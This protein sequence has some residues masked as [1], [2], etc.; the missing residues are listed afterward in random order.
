MNKI[1]TV[2]CFRMAM[3]GFTAVIVFISAI[4]IIGVVITAAAKEKN[5]KEDTAPRVCGIYYDMRYCDQ[6]GD[7]C[8]Y[9]L[10]IFPGGS[11]DPEH[12]VRLLTDNNCLP[13]RESARVSISDPE[14]FLI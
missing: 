11:A 10:F 4:L 14:I 1:N 13:V 8:G 5:A 2:S 9:E 7:L 6:S 12:F 3:K